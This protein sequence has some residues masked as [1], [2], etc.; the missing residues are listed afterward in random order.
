MKNSEI[1]DHWWEYFLVMWWGIS[2]PKPEKLIP[3]PKDIKLD[4]ISAD[5][6]DKIET[7]LST[8]DE[9]KI[10]SFNK[11]LDDTS[12]DDDEIKKTI[13]SKAHS[14]IGLTSIAVSL[15]LAGISFAINQSQHINILLQFLLWLIFLLL[16][17]N[18]LTAGMHARNVVIL[19]KG[20]ARFNFEPLLDDKKKAVDI[21][22]DKIMINNY[23]AYLN[24]IKATYLK[25]SHWYFKSSFI[26]TMVVALLLPPL[27]IFSNKKVDN[28]S[29]KQKINIINNNYNNAKSSIP[30][31]EPII[32][33]KCNK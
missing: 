19:T 22:L 1:F 12:K 20:Y 24:R 5:F 8:N 7:L 3:P 4:N 15:L 33:K 28:S 18:F 17:I 23:N 30:L 6:K 32:S 14:L 26:L 11:I 16:I 13:E 10:N 21:I 29:D 2:T 31:K 9:K 25:F 27:L